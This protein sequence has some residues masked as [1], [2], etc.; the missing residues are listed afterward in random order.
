MGRVH[1]L[2]PQ[3]RG[4]ASYRQVVIREALRD[5]PVERL[6]LAQFA[7]V[8]PD[9]PVR[10]LVDGYLLRADQRAFPV[11][12]DHRLEGMVCLH[13]VRKLA[14]GA[15]D[16]TLVRDIMV[17]ADRLA[18]AGPHDDAGAVLSRLAAQ[19]FNQL[20][21]LEGGRVRGLV[22]REDILK[23]LALYADRA[24]ER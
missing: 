22:R 21:V 14:R 12:A 9:L 16:R 19:N 7:T 18:V 3:Q 17:P 8:P 10:A 5:V 13:D 15:W 1:R 2:V 4:S 24:V 20:P 11:V 23:W 6:M